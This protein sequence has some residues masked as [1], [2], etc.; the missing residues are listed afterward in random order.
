[1]G[2]IFKNGKNYGG[3]LSPETYN[4]ISHISNPNLLINPDFKINTKG[5]N[6]YS[7]DNEVFDTVDKWIAQKSITVNVGDEGLTISNTDRLDYTGFFQ[8]IESYERLL[9]KTVTM[10]ICAKGNGVIRL[11]PIEFISNTYTDIELTDEFRVYTYTYVIP[12]DI[13]SI[14]CGICLCKT[15]NTEVI[16]KYI[17]Y[18]EGEYNTP[19][20]IPDYEVEKLKCIGV[21]R[22]YRAEKS[23]I[24]NMLKYTLET[25]TINGVECRNNGDGTYTLNGTAEE[26]TLFNIIFSTPMI[27]SSTNKKFVC[28]PKSFDGIGYAHLGT[29]N[30]WGDMDRG[31]GVIISTNDVTKISIVVAKGNTCD[32]VVVKPMIT[33]NLNAT[34]D[35]FVPYTGDTGELNKDIADIKKALSTLLTV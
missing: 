6:V 26:N 11:C 28:C 1:M 22:L 31:N 12:E 27:I 16:L 35:D 4:K 23:T 13:G 14:N 21:D 7:S 24:T 2:T 34:Y 9:G 17:K 15:E 5:Y 8:T 20:T 30:G 3:G 32:N 29:S 10:T 33:T 25:T 18:E 19:F